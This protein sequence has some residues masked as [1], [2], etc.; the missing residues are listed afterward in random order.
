VFDVVEAGDWD[1]KIISYHPGINKLQLGV[2]KRDLQKKA[3]EK[4]LQEKAKKQAQLEKAKREEIFKKVSQKI[5]REKAEKQA[6]QEKAKKRAEYEG[7]LDWGFPT[8]PG[9][10]SSPMDPLLIGSIGD[11]VSPP[12]DPIDIADYLR[13]E[14]YW[15]YSV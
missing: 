8:P 15:V 6:L 3:E 10:V 4:V 5:L 14:Q 11:Y 13:T 2:I 7:Y 9:Y 12:M 1:V